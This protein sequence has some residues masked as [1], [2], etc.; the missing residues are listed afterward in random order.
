MFPYITST[1]ISFGPIAIQTW[2]FF[3]ALGIFTAIFFTARR[4]KKNGLEEN[5]AWDLGVWILVAAFLGARIFHVVFYE[6]L[7]YWQNP[8]Q[9]L[10][11][12]QGGLSVIGGFLGALGVSLWYLN[13]KNLSFWDYAPHAIFYLP[14]GLSIG[15]VGCAFIHDHPGIACSGTC[16]FALNSPRG[17]EYDLGFLLVINNFAL[18]LFFLFLDQKGKWKKYYPAIFLLWYGFTRFFL[19]FLRIWDGPIADL[20]YWNLTPA[21][22][23]SVVFFAVGLWMCLHGGRFKSNKVY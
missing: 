23:S 16:F 21:Q 8:F 4:L 6:P 15:R 12:W 22:Y 17:P 20:R 5:I 19:D 9:I 14:L 2:G 13:K 10:A 18:F 11:I 3:V 1:T 7:Y